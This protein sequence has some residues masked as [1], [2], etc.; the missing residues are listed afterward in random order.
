MYNVPTTNVKRYVAWVAGREFVVASLNVHATVYTMGKYNSMSIVDCPYYASSGHTRLGARP[1]V[2]TEP[3]MWHLRRRSSVLLDYTYTLALIHCGAPCGL[4]A[5]VA[6]LVATH[7]SSNIKLHT[8]PDSCWSQIRTCV[9]FFISV[10]PDQTPHMTLKSSQLETSHVQLH[11]I[12]LN[13]SYTQAQF[14]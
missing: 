6:W 12:S 9:Q 4:A 7:C 13:T 10:I 14:I 11:L 8:M 3:G 2:R 1:G 5:Q